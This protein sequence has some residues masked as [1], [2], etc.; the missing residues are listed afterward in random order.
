[1]DMQVTPTSLPNPRAFVPGLIFFLAEFA[2]SDNA[3]HS[4]SG[5]AAILALPRL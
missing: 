5:I 2:A 3:G 4:G 1:M